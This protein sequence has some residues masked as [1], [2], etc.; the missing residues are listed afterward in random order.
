VLALAGA[1]TLLAVVAH[2]TSDLLVIGTAIPAA[3]VKAIFPAVTV[4]TVLWILNSNL[5]MY[6]VR[7]LLARK[8][9]AIF[10]LTAAAALAIGLLLNALG[11][12]GLLTIINL[13][14]AAMAAALMIQMRVLSRHGVSLERCYLGLPLV[15]VPLLVSLLP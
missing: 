1:S 12:I 15:G 8:A 10:V 3:S 7:E 11:M 13:Y 4:Q 5:E 9:A 14:S 6:V 2:F